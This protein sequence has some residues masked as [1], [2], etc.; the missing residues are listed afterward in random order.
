MKA[1]KS[2]MQADSPAIGPQKF[3]AGCGSCSHLS[4]AGVVTLILGKYD[5][6]EYGVGGT[7]A[8]CRVKGLKACQNSRLVTVY[9][10]S[11]KS[12][13]KLGKFGATD[14]GHGPGGSY[15]AAS[16]GSLA[17]WSR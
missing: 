6:N 16:Q 13:Q 12:E 1:A 5:E 4:R 2:K 17:A 10:T 15:K 14:G 3:L 11:I 7:L 8:N 9:F